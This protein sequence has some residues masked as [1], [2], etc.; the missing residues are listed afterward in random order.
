VCK[1]INN[2]YKTYI[3]I[4]ELKAHFA[5]SFIY[6]KK[7]KRGFLNFRKNLFINFLRDIKKYKVEYDTTF[8]LFRSTRII[9]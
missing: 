5:L 7:P 9:R 1:T 4:V 6:D 2:S 3:N 8:P